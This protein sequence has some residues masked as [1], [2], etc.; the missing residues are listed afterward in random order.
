MVDHVR[1]SELSARQGKSL[2]FLLIS[3]GQRLNEQGV[4]GLNRKGTRFRL[5]AAH[6]RL[7]PLLM[8]PGGVRIVDAA[9]M[10]EVSKQAVQPLVAE[11]EAAGLVTV[12]AD[13]EDARARRIHVTAAG[14][15]SMHD[16]MG[17]LEGLDV[18]LVKKLGPKKAKALHALLAEVF[19]GLDEA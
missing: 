4:D 3:C 10:L 7:V 15:R 8:Q 11:L 13:P 9:R 19:S 2:A 14:L 6:T 16:G 18:G 5:R 17:V 12:K 1:F